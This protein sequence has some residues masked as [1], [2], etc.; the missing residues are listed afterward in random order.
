MYELFLEA[1]KYKAAKAEAARRDTDT[2]TFYRF[3]VKRYA[4]HHLKIAISRLL[5]KI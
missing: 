5:T 3:A 1:N 4:A 2:H